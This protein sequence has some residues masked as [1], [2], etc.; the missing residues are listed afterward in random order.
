L[1]STDRS[2]GFTI[3]LIILYF[4]AASRSCMLT[5]LNPV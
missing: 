5:P 1:D 4:P 3:R 2:V